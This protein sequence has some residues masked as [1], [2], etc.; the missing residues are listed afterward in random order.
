MIRP[1]KLKLPPEGERVVAE[2]RPIRDCSACREKYDDPRYCAPNRCYCGHPEC[3]AY[4][5]Y[6]KPY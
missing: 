4:A 6:R 3:P 1:I 2:P 5:S